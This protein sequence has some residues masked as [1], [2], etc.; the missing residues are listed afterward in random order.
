MN[1]TMCPKKHEP[2]NSSRNPSTGKVAHTDQDT[3]K[4]QFAPDQD[5]KQRILDSLSVDDLALADPIKPSATPGSAYEKHNALR[6]AKGE[7]RR[8]LDD[9]RKLSEHIK[10]S[11]QYSQPPK[12]NR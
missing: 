5:D 9:L 10:K 12:V 1:A 7:R 2:S 3:G 6:P 11:K 4:W 8:S